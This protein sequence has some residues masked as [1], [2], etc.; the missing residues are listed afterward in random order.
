MNDDQFKSDVVDALNRIAAYLK[1]ATITDN[2]IR[3]EA[4]G[5]PDCAR[6][7]VVDDTCR[8]HQARWEHQ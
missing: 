8:Y 5:C 1:V 3:R 6:D 4:F 7:D 2:N